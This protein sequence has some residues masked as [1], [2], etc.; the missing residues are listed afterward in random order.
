MKGVVIRVGRRNCAL[1]Q[2]KQPVNIFVIE[3]Q[4]PFSIPS[5]DVIEV[6]AIETT[7]R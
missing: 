4:A 6:N 3:P 5:V 2:Q 7:D 1:P